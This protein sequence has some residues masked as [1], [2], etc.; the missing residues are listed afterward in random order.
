MWFDEF[1]KI[2]PALQ[3]YE[4][5]TGYF[6]FPDEVA[7]AVGASSPPSTGMEIFREDLERLLKRPVRCACEPTRPTITIRCDARE[8]PSLPMDGY[9]IDIGSEGMLLVAHSERSC[10]YGMQTLLQLIAL[11]RKKNRVGYCSVRDW[12]HYA[13]RWATLDLGRAPFSLSYLKRIVRICARLKYNGLHL[14]LHDNEL[15]AVVYERLPLGSENPFALPL[16][17]YAELIRYAA[18]WHVEIVP[19][20]ES[21]GHVGSLLQHY[22]H[23]YGATRKHGRGHSFAIGPETFDLLAEMYRQWMEIL[24][25]GSVL[26]VGLDEANWRLARGADPELYTRQNLVRHV[27][28]LVRECAVQQGKDIQMMMWQDWRYPPDIVPDDLRDSIIAQPWHYHTPPMIHHMLSQLKL[29]DAHRNGGSKLTPLPFVAGAGA[30]GIHELGAM[31]ASRVWAY[32]ARNM[33]NCLG[34]DITLWGTNDLLHDMPTLYY[35]A[36]C[37][38]NPVAANLLLPEAES[39]ENEWGVV[40]TQMKHWQAAFPDADPEALACERGPEIV[41]GLYRWGEK[42]GEECVPIWMPEKLFLGDAEPPVKNEMPPDLVAGA[43]Q[44]KADA[45]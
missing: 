4:K 35:G 14:H 30:S 5:H 11:E 19:E 44:L 18:E 17:A 39:P 38:W 21:W 24:P 15:N 41:H 2:T 45:V 43:T 3:H 16:P 23:L 12:P 31:Q 33:A 29:P 13:K 10:F 9:T 22:P 27:H 25:N 8:T 40:V 1:T 32:E 7:V 26:H 20:L 42:Y 37:A 34:I 28:E 36:D 6:I